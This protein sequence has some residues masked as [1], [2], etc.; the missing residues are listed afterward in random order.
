ML[1][2]VLLT[3]ALLADLAAAALDAALAVAAAGLPPGSTPARLAIIGMGK[4]GG[5]ELNYRSDVDIVAV[6]EPLAGGDEAAALAT[7]TRLVISLV[8]VCGTATREGDLFPVDLALRPE[9]KAGALVRSLAS[10]ESYYRSWAASWE[11]QALLKARPVAGDLTLGREW[12]ERLAPMVWTTGARPDLPGEVQAM[13][14]RVESTLP[15]AIADREIKLG[16]GGLRDIEFAVQLL[17]LVHGRSDPSLR[18]GS[19]LAALEALSAGGYVGR[20][21]AAALDA[22]YRFLRLVEH[23]VQLQRLRR[24]H[25]VPAAGDPD[26]E[27]LA[28]ACGFKADALATFDLELRRH[29]DAARRLHEKLF[30]RPLLSASATLAVSDAHLT[31]VAAEHRLQA[32]GFL[33]TRQALA[34]LAAL[35]TGVSRRAA[36]QRTLLPVLLLWFAEEAD[37]DAGLLAFRRLSDSLGETPWFLRSLRDEGEIAQRLAHLLARSRYVADLLARAPEA[38]LMLGDDAALRPRSGDRLAEEF[39]AV[40][41]RTPRAETAV[42]TARSLRRLELLRIAAADLL[43]LIDGPQVQAALS[44]LAAATIAAALEVAQRRVAAD[45]GLSTRLAVIAMGRLGSAELGYASDADVLFLH[46]AVTGQSDAEARG[47][48]A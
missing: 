33:E 44:E 3:S 19:T 36:I 20:S 11:L 24:T 6:A 14:R 34:H 48:N 4:C 1:A 7:A 23:R 46:E 40:V 22:A 13:R 17:Q 28:R 5:R 31:P 9:G 12:I 38:M 2:G 18:S 30:Y 41:R 37:P 35:T 32:L 43:G 16:R 25:L 47:V 27:W 42:A 15:A 26:R 10:H 8:R 39:L 45:T 29:G 21:D